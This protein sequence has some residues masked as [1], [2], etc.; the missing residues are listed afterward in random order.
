MAEVKPCEFRGHPDRAILSQ[1]LLR[2]GAE[3]ILYGVHSSEWKR[4]ALE[5]GDDIV[6]S[7]WEH[8]GV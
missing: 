4:M 5:R 8:A 3:T 7:A 1:A 6:R 2:D